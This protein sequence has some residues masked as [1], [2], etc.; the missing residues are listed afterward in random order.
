MAITDKKISETTLTQ[1]G[2]VSA[3]DQLKG[4]AQENKARFDQL[5]RAIVAQSINPII[6]ELA[7]SAGA[8][9][10]GASIGDLSGDNVQSLLSALKA[11]TDHVVLESGN[12]TP[13]QVE[14]W[15][16]AWEKTRSSPNYAGKLTVHV[17]TTDEGSLGDTKV[18]VRNEA[19]G[20]Y[21]VQELDALGDTTFELLENHTYYIYLTDY[22]E[23]YFGGATVAT[24]E[25]KDDQTVTI[26][27]DTEPDTIGWKM[28][29]A[30]GEIT[31]TDG[32]ENFVPASMGESFDAGSWQGSWLIKNIKPCV[33]KNGVVQYYLD[34]NDFTKKTDGTAAD[35]TSGND[36]DVMVEFPLV[37]Y[38]FYSE[39]GYIGCQFSR[40]A[41][42]GF[43]APAFFNLS[44]IPQTTMYMAAY[45]GYSLSS[46]LRS[47]SGK[48]PTATTT[49]GDFRTL[50]TANGTGYQQ[51]EW[52]KRTLLQTMFMMVFKDTDSQTKLG[53]GVTSASAAINTG[54]M[55]DKGMFWG[56]QTGTNGVKC[57]GIENLW[58]NIRKWCDGIEKYN[59][60]YEIKQYA[61]YNDTASGYINPA[62]FSG[63]SGEF[64][65]SVSINGSAIFPVG[66][67]A[68]EA[69]SVIPDR[70]YWGSTGSTYYLCSTGGNWG[71]TSNAGLFYLYLGSTAASASTNIGASLSF[72]PQ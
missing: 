36:G 22:P 32:A 7:S 72:T 1:E 42:D 71:E 52:T 33:L 70:I 31:Y 30:T 11:Y 5:T 40:V 25:S 39:T 65:K 29:T 68:N 18:T 6:D 3:P 9:N 54:T 55:N 26:T 13:E 57:F 64:I 41:Q 34:P 35:I 8:A 14:R 37:Y 67:I 38:K 16:D 23:T 60:S 59:S 48:T 12:V 28:N 69:E 63:T 2:L 21:Y 49:I 24:V 53:K 56:D 45:D 20:A 44:G 27:M 43:S 61:P 62:A 50:A 4:T 15:D 10:I 66:T 51:Q 19:L 46:K 17:A 47:L 58:G